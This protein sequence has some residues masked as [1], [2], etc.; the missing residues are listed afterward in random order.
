M[1]TDY[2][3][4]DVGQFPLSIGTS[5]AI[6]GLLGF[7]PAAPSQPA[8]YK[9]MKCLWVNVRTLVRNLYQAMKSEDAEKVKFVDAMHVVLQEMQTIPQIFLDQKSPMRVEFYIEDM[10]EFK[11]EYPKATFKVAK[12]E[13]QTAYRTYEDLVMRMLFEYL[14]DTKPQETVRIVGRNPGRVH[15]T[16]IILTHQ[17]HHLLWQKSFD[18]L[19]LLESHTGKIKIYTS[20]FTKLNGVTDDRPIPFTRFT[21]QVFGDGQLFEGLD[22][23]IK[24]EL[25]QIAEF[26]KW[27]GITTHEK[28]SADIYRGG[29]QV[30]KAKYAELN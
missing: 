27:T 12:T 29:S 21:L 20:W 5:M 25:R 19:M 23:K 3:I 8:G 10:A 7:H 22:R 26:K 2:I 9:A 6:E 13:K 15:D 4:R 16:V 14:R 17:P 30:L 24:A 28:M 1:S 18:R 11:W